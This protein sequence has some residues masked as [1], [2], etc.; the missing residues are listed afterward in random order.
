MIWK[1]FSHN[2]VG[3]LAVFHGASKNTQ[4]EWSWVWEWDDRV[5]QNTSIGLENMQKPER[6]S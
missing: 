6:L 4:S 3:K 5:E 1:F 2:E